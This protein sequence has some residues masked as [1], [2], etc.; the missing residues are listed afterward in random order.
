MGARLDSETFDY[1]IVGAG[2]AGSLL[3]AR[4]AEKPGITVCVL[5][6][7]PCEQRP[8]VWIPAGYVR[9]LTQRSIGWNF[10]SQPAC[11]G[12]SLALYQGRVV[13][14]SSSINGMIYVRGQPEDYDDWAALGLRGWSYGDVLPHFRRSETRIGSGDDAVRGR[15]GP[16]TVGD[17]GWSHP[18]SDAFVMAAQGAGWEWNPDYNSGTQE[19]VAHVQ[20]TVRRGWRATPAIAMLRPALRSGSI[21]LKTRSRAVQIIFD[22]QRAIGIRYV[23]SRGGIEETVI[24]K[25]EVIL[26]CGAI[27]TPRLL[28]VSGVGDGRSLGK[29]GVP[30]V[31]HL[32]GVGENLRDHF[33]SRIVM[34]ARDGVP[35]LNQMARG[36]RL[37]AE[38]VRWM[39]GR[40]SVLTLSP[41]HVFLSCRSN[42]EFA[43]PDLQCMF[44]PGSFGRDRAGRLDSHPGVT[45]AWW[46]HRP[47]SQGY[48]RALAKDVFVDPEIQPN[49]LAALADQTTVIAGMQLMAALLTGVELAPV[50]SGM[51][52]PSSMP[53]TDEEML[54]FCRDSGTAG[55]HFVGTARMGPAGDPLRVVDDQLRVHGIEKLRVADASIMPTIPSA[56]TYAAT[57][58][59]GEKATVMLLS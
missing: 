21:E 29:I 56:N 17:V 37:L 28:Q 41:S 49:Y 27:N 46:Q 48:V 25:R 40:P 42:P 16:I 12:Q 43:R 47:E 18:A 10:T 15:T 39:L 52:Q 54:A 51:I 44:T 53:G 24:A 1:V 20:Q 14:G 58:M 38:G 3:A 31:H 4:L 6:A 59:I 13:G 33:V 7:G 34:R 11:A 9:A 32:P 2:T 30:L 55:C 57:M 23:R 19:G 8:E 22:K 50:L 36:P 45:G 35:T 26:C 5:E